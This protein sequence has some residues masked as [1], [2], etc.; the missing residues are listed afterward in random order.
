MLEDIIVNGFVDDNY[1]SKSFPASNLEKQKSTQRKFEHTLA[2]IKSWMDMM[3]L[4]LNT[5]KTEY[6]TFGSKAQLWKISK[7]S[8]T[9]GNHVIQMTPYIKCLGGTLDN[10][11]KF[12][13]HNHEDMES[14][15]KLCI[16]KGNT[17]IPHQKSMHK[18][19]T[20]PMYN[21]PGL[22]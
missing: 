11:L 18:T 5:N 2:V 22:W 4:R 19:S 1:L 15:V 13:R 12:N 6:I 14:N 8:L 16:Y 17:E 7:T 3:R 9:I 21:A 10:K 20:I